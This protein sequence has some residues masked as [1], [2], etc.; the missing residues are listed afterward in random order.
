MDSTL[1]LC[2]STHPRIKMARNSIPC[3]K[4]SKSLIFFSLVYADHPRVRATNHQVNTV[5][6]RQVICPDLLL[7]KLWSEIYGKFTDNN[8]RF[9]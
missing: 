1:K 2:E 6:P 3:A 8:C 4:D 5:F 9:S 7:H